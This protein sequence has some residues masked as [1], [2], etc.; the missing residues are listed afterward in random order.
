[1]K[2]HDIIIEIR[3]RKGTNSSKITKKEKKEELR[4][5]YEG[6]PIQG[7]SW[8]DGELP[9]IYFYFWLENG[10]SKRPKVF[11]ADQ[12]FYVGERTT[13][14]QFYRG[15]RP[16]IKNGKDERYRWLPKAQNR[17]VYAVAYELPSRS[18][19][20]R[21]HK[22]RSLEY[23]VAKELIDRYAKDTAIFA[24][25]G[26]FDFRV[27]WLRAADVQRDAKSLLAKLNSSYGV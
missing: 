15:W 16:P 25:N 19:Y 23:F 1:M 6:S 11:T 4:L 14:S 2:T 27:S 24:Y 26:R 13:A 18:G 5:L 21:T 8:P 7:H 22:R 10:A 3:Q 17:R 20:H 12:L 9:I